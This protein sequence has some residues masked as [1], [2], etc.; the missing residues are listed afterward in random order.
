[1]P[2]LLTLQCLALAVLALGASAIP[3]AAKITAS[4]DAGFAISQE[5]EI[6]GGAPMAVWNALAHPAKWWGRAHTWSGDPAN[7]RLQP[8]IAGGCFCDLTPAADTVP[9]AGWPSVEHAQIIAAVPGT[10]SIALTLGKDGAPISV[11]AMPLAAS[12]G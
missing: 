11:G 8:V 5:T 10:P 12:C 1:M 2:C 9:A 3:A 6:P 4:S 7:P